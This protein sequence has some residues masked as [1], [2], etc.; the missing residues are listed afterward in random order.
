MNEVY[1]VDPR[2]IHIDQRKQD[3]RRDAW[4]RDYM[5]ADWVKPQPKTNRRIENAKP[6]FIF[7]FFYV[8]IIV[9]IG[10]QN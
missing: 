10:S 7:A 5:P 8:A 9:M 4:D 1:K 6:V 3:T 2:T